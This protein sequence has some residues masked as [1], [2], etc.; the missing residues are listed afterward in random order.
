MSDWKHYGNAGHFICSSRCRFHLCTEVGEYLVSTVGEYFRT[1]EDKE[2]TP[3]GGWDKEFYETMVFKWEGRCSCGCGLPEIDPM[4]LE[5]VRY[6]TPKEANEGHLELCL[7]YNSLRPS[8]KES[9][10][11]NVGE[12][13]NE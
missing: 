13:D 3:V 10:E 12:S 5:C 8:V 2:M 7:K 6:E 9:S 11:L 4:N 1:P